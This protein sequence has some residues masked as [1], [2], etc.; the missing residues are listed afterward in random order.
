MVKSKLLMCGDPAVVVHLSPGFVMESFTL[1]LD[2]HR[3]TS[4]CAQAASDRRHF[5]KR[6]LFYKPPHSVYKGERHL[7]I[8]NAAE[9]PTT[10]PEKLAFMSPHVAVLGYVTVV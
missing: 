7:P 9:L 4:K 5:Y 6:N 8:T 1:S 3:A 2:H 10:F